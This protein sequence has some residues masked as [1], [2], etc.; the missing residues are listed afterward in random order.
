MIR[1]LPGVFA[2]QIYLVATPLPTVDAL[3]DESIEA[4]RLRAEAHDTETAEASGGR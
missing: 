4:S 3:L 2:Y 1:Q